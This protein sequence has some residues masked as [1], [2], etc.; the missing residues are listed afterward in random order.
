MGRSERG[1]GVNRRTNL[2]KPGRSPVSW[3][4]MDKTRS[5]LQ[6]FGQGCCACGCVLTIFGMVALCLLL[7]FLEQ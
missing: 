5:G 3:A 6:Q 2:D 7:A 1:A 4:A